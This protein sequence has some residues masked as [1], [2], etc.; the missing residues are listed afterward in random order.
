MRDIEERQRHRQRERSRLPAESLMQVLHF[1]SFINF[2]TNTLFFIFYKDFIY[3]FERAQAGQG[4]EGKADSP[5]SS[6][7]DKV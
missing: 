3:L 4:A 1:I 5:L 7:A 6:E 2:L